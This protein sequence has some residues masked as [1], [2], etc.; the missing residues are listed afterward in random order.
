[1]AN[2]H[3]KRCSIANVIKER[4]IKTI[5]SHYT[6]IR[7]VQIQNTDKPN[8]G[9]DVEQEELSFLMEMKNDAATL[10]GSLAVSYKTP[11]DPA[12]QVLSI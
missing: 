3:M 5:R 6:P 10:K 4:Q 1:M 11:Y 7:M 8:A 12:I 2:K 9:E